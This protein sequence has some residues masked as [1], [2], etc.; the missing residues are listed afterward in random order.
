MNTS[1]SIQDNPFTPTFG[2]APS[3]LAGRAQLTTA[4][5][6]A[7]TSPSRRP[8]LTSLFY[9]ARGT[10]KTTLLSITAH[11]A[12][13]AGWI[14]V[15]AAALPGMLDDIEI[16]ARKTAAHLLKQPSSKHISRFGVPNVVDI[17]VTK[18]PDTASNWRSRMTA[19]LDELESQNSGIVITVDEIDPNL[20]ELAILASVYQIFVSE[21]RRIA[22]FMAGLPNSTSQL[23][24]SQHVSF[25]RRAQ[26]TRLGRIADY[27][28]REALIKTIHDGG[29]TIRDEALD[30]AVAAIDGFAYLIQL[31]GYRAWDIHPDQQEITVDDM[32]LGIASAQSEMENHLIAASYRE[33][34]Q[35][36]IKFLEAMVIDDG[37]ARSVTLPSV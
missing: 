15:R 34:S 32:K 2:E 24:S 30:L 33:L 35:G 10:G 31:V 26:L 6:R 14:P 18:A 37:T 5:E 13:E 22:L 3:H 11:L 20:D 19:I 36:D 9:G 1:I 29:R 23:L 28:V 25:L 7:L 4:I 17:E 21:G 16:T 8:E 27:D 12:Q